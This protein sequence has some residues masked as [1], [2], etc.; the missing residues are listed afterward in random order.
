MATPR[1]R[2]VIEVQSGCVSAVYSDQELDIDILL[3][4]HDA[5]AVGQH[6]GALLDC[7]VDREAVQTLWRERG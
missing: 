3:L 5:E 6:G 7:G 4:D 1:P 2:L